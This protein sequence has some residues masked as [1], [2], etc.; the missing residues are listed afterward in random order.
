MLLVVPYIPGTCSTSQ[1]VENIYTTGSERDQSRHEVLQDAD[2]QEEGGRNKKEES[3]TLGL[4]MK[5]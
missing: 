4:S 5:F 3:H 1:D 2:E